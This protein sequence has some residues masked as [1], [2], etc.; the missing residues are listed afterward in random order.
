M[1]PRQRSETHGTTTW[2]VASL[3]RSGVDESSSEVGN[4]PD[5]GGG[6]ILQPRSGVDESSSEVGNQVGP[7]AF[8]HG[9][10]VRSR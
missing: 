1:N 6:F 9:L 4:H 2:A 10:S 8:F 5:A 7:A 3:S